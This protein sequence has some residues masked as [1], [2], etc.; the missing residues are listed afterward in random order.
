M[1]T[2][3]ARLAVVLGA[4]KERCVLTGGAMVS[5]YLTDPQESAPRPTKDVDV[6]IDVATVHEFR[7]EVESELRRLGFV[8]APE[9]GDPIC[10][11][12]RDDNVVD[13]MPTRSELLGFSNRWYAD[14]FATACDITITDR[15]I[16][17]AMPIHYFLASK[18]EAFLGRGVADPMVSQ[19][20]EDVISIINGRP[21][22]FG[23]ISEA[24]GEVRTFVAASCRKL[25]DDADTVQ[26]LPGM[27]PPDRASQQRI[28]LV[29]E[30][31]E[32]L[33]KMERNG[34]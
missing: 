25:L 30:R 33:A 23:E 2:H 26:S 24:P 13:V 6:I 31:I 34:P 16:W 29:L 15:C 1:R 28:R 20:L 3:I 32:S 22:L 4:L 9:E 18:L 19:D 7:E 8:N 5:F 10:R 14:G 27:L 21:E 12:R 17:R 11:W